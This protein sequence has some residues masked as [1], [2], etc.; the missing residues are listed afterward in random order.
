MTY[1]DALHE[2]NNNVHKG[3]LLSDQQQATRTPSM[4]STFGRRTSKDWAPRLERVGELMLYS[5]RVD[6]IAA[7]AFRHAA[8]SKVM[9][10]DARTQDH[11][12]DI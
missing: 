9:I 7:N 4:S 1:A 11:L 2:Q 10:V 5:G 3:R 6:R 8:D 12:K